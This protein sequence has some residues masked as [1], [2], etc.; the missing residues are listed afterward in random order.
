LFV[1]QFLCNFPYETPLAISQLYGIPEIA[2][3]GQYQ[4]GFTFTRFR[5]RALLRPER[6]CC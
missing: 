4:Q 6:W 3:G 5:P 2:S 1:G